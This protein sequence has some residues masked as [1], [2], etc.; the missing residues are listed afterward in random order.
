MDFKAL[1]FAISTYNMYV[2]YVHMY[3]EP[4]YLMQWCPKAIILFATH[5]H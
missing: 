1:S 2:W 4:V 5:F 3:L